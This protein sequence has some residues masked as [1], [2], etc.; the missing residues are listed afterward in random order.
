[1]R[2]WV[3][4]WTAHEGGPGDGAG[5]VRG[6]ACGPT[7]PSFASPL[8]LP[9]QADLAFV[10]AAAAVACLAT[11]VD[12][13]LAAGGGGRGTAAGVAGAFAR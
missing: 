11:V 8:P 12:S 7:S 2:A 3:A 5:E 9:P 13:Q 10:G 1:M 4:G 6:Q